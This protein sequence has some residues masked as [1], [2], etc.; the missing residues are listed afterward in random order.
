MNRLQ[1]TSATSDHLSSL[2]RRTA[3]PSP[4]SLPPGS[5]TAAALQRA[6][7]SWVDAHREADATLRE[8]VQDV[9]AFAGR[10]RESDG[11]LASTLE[12]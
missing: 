4:P 12:F 3:D 7:R 10:V 6:A 9:R 11:R 2:L 5:R 8:H 1:L